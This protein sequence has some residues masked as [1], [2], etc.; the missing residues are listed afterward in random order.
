M[1][2]NRVAL[3]ETQTEGS[4]PAL[5]LVRYQFGN[6]LGSASL[7]LDESGQIITYEEYLPY[8]STSYQAGSTAAEVSLKRYRYAGMERDEETGLCS[9]MVRGISATWL[10][11]W[12]SCDPELSESITGHNP[13]ASMPRYSG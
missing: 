11:R 1:I 6:H 10:G 2:S 3:V 9:I 5:Q 7:E 8:G 12:T 13:Q 4:D